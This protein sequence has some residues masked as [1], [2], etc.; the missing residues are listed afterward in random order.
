MRLRLQRKKEFIDLSKTP[1]GTGEYYYE[2]EEIEIEMFR[3]LKNH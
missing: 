1:S 2:Y 3:W